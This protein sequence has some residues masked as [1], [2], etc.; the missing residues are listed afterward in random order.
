MTK[1]AARKNLN[2]LMV[3]LRS[4]HIH[5][6]VSHPGSALPEHVTGQHMITKHHVFAG[7]DEFNVIS[8]HWDL[9]PASVL[10]YF[11]DF[12]GMY[13][14]V[15]Q[16]V[17]YNYPTYCKRNPMLS[18][19]DEITNETLGPLYILPALRQMYPD[20][21]V[22]YLDCYLNILTLNR[23]KSVWLVMDQAIYLI[24]PDNQVFHSDVTKDIQSKLVSC[25]NT[26]R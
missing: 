2:I 3:L 19:T 9:P 14:N 5:S 25:I 7:S 21:D 20:V 22:V 10:T 15:S 23:T 4:V 17:Y 12:S 16:V 24:T 18:K 8:M 26:T 11:H 1:S 6:I 13:N